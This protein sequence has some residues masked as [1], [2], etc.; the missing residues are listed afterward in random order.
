MHVARNMSELIKD[1]SLF[2]DFHLSF[3]ASLVFAPTGNVASGSHSVKQLPLIIFNKN[4]ESRFF[5]LG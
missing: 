5:F 4:S 1:T 3:W 2:Q